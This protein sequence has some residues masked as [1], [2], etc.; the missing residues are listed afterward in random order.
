MPLDRLGSLPSWLLS[1]SAGH[2]H[3][4]LGEALAEA[5]AHGYHYRLLAALDERGA[6]SQAAVGRS[7]EIDASDVVAALAEL[8]GEGLVERATDPDDARRKIV[9]ITGTGRRRLK[10]LDAVVADV[11][12]ELL[13]PLSS[14]ERA[15]LVS[16]LGRVARRSG[17]E[18]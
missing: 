10:R 9:T 8:E 13:A 4:L 12:A 14:D 7:A 18:D 3:H 17:E 6:A 15:Q 16:L 5:G 1:R 2:A 11:Q